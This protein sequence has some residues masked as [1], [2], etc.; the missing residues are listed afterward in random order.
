MPDS[1]SNT[2]TEVTAASSPSMPAAWLGLPPEYAF[3]EEPPTLAE[4]EEYC[5]RLATSHYENFSVVSWFL[6]EQLRRHFYNLYAHCRIADDLGDEV[7]DS[8]QALWLLDQWE[9]ELN[10]TYES[11]PLKPGAAKEAKIEEAATEPVADGAEP[12]TAEGGEPKAEEAP[13]PEPETVQRPERAQAAEDVEPR[14]PVF[15]ALRETIRECQIPKEPFADLLTAFRRD[16][17]VHR[18]EKFDD[19]LDYCH[20]SANPVGRL[21]L[22]VCGYRDPELQQLSDFT[23]TALQLA[24]FWQDVAVDFD[25]G[26]VYLPLE[27]MRR[28]GVTEDDIAARRVT[29]QFLE[30]MAFQVARARQW[31]AQGLP[32]AQKVDRELAIDIELFTRGGQEILNCIERRNY[33]VLTS[34]PAISKPRKFWLVAVAALRSKLP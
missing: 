22:Y 18:F 4:S 19:L 33:D 9:A 15:V 23:C 30:L 24:N 17:V 12:E 6:P 3:P 25:K 11:L 10:R 31:F 27:D 5:R 21:V 1:E 32:L 20:F 28:F 2:Q 34:R 8:L 16:Q 13:K 26:R 29:P 7:G 14:H